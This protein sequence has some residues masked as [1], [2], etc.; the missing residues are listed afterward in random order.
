MDAGTNSSEISGLIMIGSRVY[1]TSR[2]NRATAKVA[3]DEPPQTK[4]GTTVSVNVYITEASAYMGYQ[5]IAKT[6]VVL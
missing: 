6:I 1:V 5:I 3:R 4:F 2:P